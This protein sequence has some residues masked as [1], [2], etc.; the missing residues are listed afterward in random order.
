MSRQTQAVYD[1]SAVLGDT[2]K[3]TPAVIRR[4]KI[5]K[6]GFMASI[7]LREITSAGWVG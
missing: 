4:E 2:I 5:A 1:N 6:W 3:G 7:I